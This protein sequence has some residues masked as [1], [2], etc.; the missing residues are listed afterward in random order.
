MSITVVLSYELVDEIVNI[1]R[2]S[3]EETYCPLSEEQRQY[4]QKQYTADI[5]K[6]WIDNPNMILSVIH[7]DDNIAGF[8][9]IV[10]P[11]G[12][13]ESDIVKDKQA[14]LG[15]IYL[16][17]KFKNI[18]LGS[19]LLSHCECICKDRCIKKIYLG[20]FQGNK[21]AIKFYKKRGFTQSHRP[22]MFSRNKRKVI[23]M[24]MF[25]KI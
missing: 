8:Y 12:K 24:R 25:K 14:E 5:I 10:L 4:Q 3:F 19:S 13:L 22:I 2:V 17:G 20:V 6:S 9:L 18:G 15:K 7:N 16:L 21:N 1:A 23:N 11:G